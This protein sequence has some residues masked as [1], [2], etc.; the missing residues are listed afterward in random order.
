M[1]I[2][3]LKLS[4]PKCQ[5]HADCELRPWATNAIHDV[6]DVELLVVS[7]CSWP[8]SCTEKCAALAVLISHQAITQLS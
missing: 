1:T 7:Q 4:T 2:K 3:H 6:Y 5:I 8:P